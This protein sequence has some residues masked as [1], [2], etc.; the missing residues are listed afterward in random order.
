MQDILGVQML[1]IYI[2]FVLGI[3]SLRPQLLRIHQVLSDVTYRLVT[4]GQ[5]LYLSS[6]IL[7]S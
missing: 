3:D 4:E 7:H 1:R 5:L 2:E 6:V